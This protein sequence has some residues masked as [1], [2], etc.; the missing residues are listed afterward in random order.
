MQKAKHFWQDEPQQPISGV[1]KVIPPLLQIC[2]RACRKLHCWEVAGMKWRRADAYMQDN[3][4][5]GPE[6]DRLFLFRLQKV[7]QPPFCA[8][9]PNTA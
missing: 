2:G 7:V 8:A 5:G 9:L 1:L 4:K 6:T 3:K